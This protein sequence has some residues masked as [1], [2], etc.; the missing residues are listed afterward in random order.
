MNPET[1]IHNDLGNIWC[2][3]NVHSGDKITIYEFD[4]EE[5][6]DMIDFI[7]MVSKDYN[8]NVN[9]VLSRY[10]PDIESKK[11]ESYTYIRADKSHGDRWAVLLA[12]DGEERQINVSEAYLSFYS[13]NQ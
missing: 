6:M 12:E 7:R 13:V 4:D 3:K 8:L 11:K 1:Y 2:D 9:D 5:Q 10:L